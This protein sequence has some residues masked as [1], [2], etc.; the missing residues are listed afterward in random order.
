MKP[1]ICALALVL[2]AWAAVMIADMLT[3]R[4]LD[5]RVTL[6]LSVD[7]KLLLKKHP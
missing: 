3:S 4:V 7:D 1:V 6:V 5:V 2:A